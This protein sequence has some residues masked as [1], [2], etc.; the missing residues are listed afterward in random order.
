MYKPPYRKNGTGAIKTTFDRNQY[1]GPGV[2]IIKIRDQIVYI[3]HSQ[4]NV[5]KTMY[6]HF[7]RWNDPTQRRVTYNKFTPG[8][9][10]N[11]IKTTASEA[12]KKET[13]LIVKHTPRDNEQKIQLAL[14]LK[15][16]NKIKKNSWD[17][18]L[19]EESAYPETAPF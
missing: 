11:I 10:V 8:L 7:Q 5:Y 1:G 2:Y 12:P 15:Q 17:A 3:G 9:T 6:R 16:K 18:F 13:E 14:D 19:E 4:S